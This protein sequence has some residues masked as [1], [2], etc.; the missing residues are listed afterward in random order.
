MRIHT[1]KELK[2]LFRDRHNKRGYYD[3]VKT[4]LGALIILFVLIIFFVDVFEGVDLFKEFELTTLDYRLRFRRARNINRD[5]VF[6][7]MGEDSIKKIGRWPWSREW[8]ATIISIL[9]QFGAKAVVFDVI[10]S[11]ASSEFSDGAMEE[12]MK[13]AN[14]VYIPYALE[15]E[16]YNKAKRAWDVR[17]IILPL[18]RFSRWARGGGHITIVPDPD[19]IIRRVPA[20][21]DY[22]SSV[23][24]QL[25]L[26][27]ACNM[28]GID[29][30][31]YKIKR[32]FF[33]RYIK[34]G[35]DK[36]E[37]IYIPVDEKNQMLVN[38]VGRWGQ[39]FKHYSFV[40][41]ITSYQSLLAK[42]EPL[43][44]LGEFK[45]KICVIGLT[46]PGLY[47][48]KP[49]PLQ[50]AYPAVGTNANVING[51]LNK[52]FVKKAPQ[53]LDA[54]III[55]LGLL[56]TANISKV[57]PVRGASIAL[58]MVL[59]Y[60]MISFAVLDILNLWV[61]F[62]HPFVVIILGYLVITFYNQI[63]VSIERAKLFTLATKDG[64]T[65]LFVI[66]HFNL[67]LEADMERIR[68]RG[69]RLSI[70][71]SD[72]DHF[73]KINDSYGHQVGDFILSEVASI[74]MACCRQLDI[75]S[76]YGGEEFIVMLPGASIEDAAMVAE[77]I[78]SRVEGH[79]FRMGD[80]TY[81]ATISLGVAEFTN[82]EDK[83]DDLIKQ[84]DGA[85]YQSKEGGRNRITKAPPKPP[86]PPKPIERI[87][88]PKEKPGKPQ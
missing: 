34:I 4:S 73:K 72:I 19:G 84:A 22:N 59:T 74:L 33:G 15:L 7:D 79:D 44:N 43:V 14:N 32:T 18:E 28:L 63:V 83:R 21:V 55:I 58:L 20:V 36:K 60:L 87:S 76:R 77:R 29:P 70:L 51:V 9:S 56:L 1:I 62:I 2:N 38:W 45:D 40:E 35:E 75:P 52:D 12:A 10:F 37:S 11:E 81:K 49:N 24:P 3:F 50:P 16:R 67:L 48:I 25:G 8:H 78:R 68:S 86:A 88:K 66:R 39:D 80:K 64:L 85:L 41:V 47:D 6:V 30:A 46:A 82:A 54:M 65:G 42:K 71:M 31:R 69:G 23:Y 13:K 26:K 27:V 17:D 53:W 5:V 61:S 57:N